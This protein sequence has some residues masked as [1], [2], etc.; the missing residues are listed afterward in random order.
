F[1]TVAARE[2]HSISLLAPGYSTPSFGAQHGPTS[3][4]ELLEV[5]AGV[6]AD[7]PHSLV[8]ELPAAIA[9][10]PRGTSVFWI[11]P[12]GS[13]DVPRAAR[14]AVE[15]GVILTVLGL[16]AASFTGPTNDSRW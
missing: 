12:L 3:L 4:A 16:D 14:L 8:D 15:S 11:G 7:S 2:G 6:E 10:A 9:S 1:A 13:R 5:L